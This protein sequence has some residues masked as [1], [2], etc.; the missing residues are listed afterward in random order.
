M[1]E[2]DYEARVAKGIALLDIKKPGWADDIDLSLLDIRSGSHCV[3]A[4]LSGEYDYRTG[5]EQLGLEHGEYDDGTY[6]LHGFQAEDPRAPGM[7]EGYVREAGYR[8]L[9]TIWR[10]EINARQTTEGTD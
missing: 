5:M 2:I 7:P 8:T 6:T 1:T 10:R 3:T 4:Q 9:N